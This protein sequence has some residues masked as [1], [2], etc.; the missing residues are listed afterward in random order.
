[1]IIGPSPSTWSR[2]FGHGRPRLRYT[3]APIAEAVIDLQVGFPAEPSLVALERFGR[4]LES[5][6]P[7][8]HPM[9][10]VQLSMKFD[11]GPIS[12]TSRTSTAIGYR[13]TNARGDRVVQ[14]R[15]NGISFS[16]MAPYGDWESF[17][18][19][20]RGLFTQYTSEL[21]PSRVQRL[22]VRY[23]NRL[24]LPARVDLA[25]YFTLTPK[26]PDFCAE[27]EG[28]FLQLVLPQKDIRGESK[29]IV[30]TGLEGATSEGAIVTL[31]DIDVFTALDWSWDEEQV[32]GLYQDLRNR[33]NDVFESIITDQVR[34]LIK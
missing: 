10:A 6:Y 17:S 4:S 22:A 16:H 8:L 32:W 24:E 3:R 12:E 28:Y 26:I 13:L 9:N 1:V 5:D 27:V 23:I 19:D 34:S 25:H 33:K 14:I 30:N 15:R 2:H 29:V 18:S 21:K 31:L 11:E 7:T 20:A